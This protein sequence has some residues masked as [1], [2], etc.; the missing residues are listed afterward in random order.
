MSTNQTT[1]TVRIKVE[2]W[3]GCTTIWYETS[4]LK[5]PTESINKRVNEQLQGLNLKK[6]EVSLSTP[7]V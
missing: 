2:T 6:V 4:K 5:N 3:D 1:K 7:I